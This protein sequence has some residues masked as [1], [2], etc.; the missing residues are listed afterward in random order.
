ML[1]R[2]SAPVGQ[3]RPISHRGRRRAWAARATVRGTGN[4]IFNAGLAPNPR[5]NLR[6]FTNM[7]D[8]S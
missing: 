7:A 4:S 2:R 8:T 5:N 3:D 6:S 1:C